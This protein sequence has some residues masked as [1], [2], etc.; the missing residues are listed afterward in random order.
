M[1]AFGRLRV[2]VCR[3]LVRVRPAPAASNSV[4]E[5]DGSLTPDAFAVSF[6]R[7]LMYSDLGFRGLDAAL[8]QV[9]AVVIERGLAGARTVFEAPFAN[10]VH[11]RVMKRRARHAVAIAI[12]AQAS[13]THGIVATDVQVLASS[14][15]IA[16][17]P[18]AGASQFADKPWISDVT[19]VHL[20]LLES[21]ARLTDCPQVES[22]GDT[23][24][25]HSSLGVDTFRAVPRV[26]LDTCTRSLDYSNWAIVPCSKPSKRGDAG[27]AVHADGL[28]A[29]AVFLVPEQI[30]AGVEARGAGLRQPTACAREVLALASAEALSIQPTKSAALATT[31]AVA[32]TPLFHTKR[33]AGSDV[34]ADATVV[35]VPAGFSIVAGRLTTGLPSVRSAATLH[36]APIA[37]R[38]MTSSSDF[39]SPL[40]FPSKIVPPH[41][42]RLDFGVR[43][44]PRSEMAIPAAN[45]R[46][47]PARG[48][49]V[50]PAL[51]AAAML[52]RM[53]EL[54]LALM[55]QDYCGQEPRYL[56][57]LEPSEAH[58]IELMNALGAQPNARTLPEDALVRLWSTYPGAAALALVSNFIHRYHEQTFWLSLEAATGLAPASLQ[59]KWGR[60]FRQFA[61]LHRLPIDR[62]RH[63]LK[64]VA[65]IQ[66]QAG[67]PTSHLRDVFELAE[68]ALD[69]AMLAGLDA[70][71]LVAAWVPRLDELARHGLR[72]PTRELFEHRPEV[73]RRYV[74]AFRALS[75]GAAVAGL[76][77]RFA[78]AFEAW[79]REGEAEQARRP[80]GPMRATLQLRK[81]QP[82]IVVGEQA[83]PNSAAVEITIQ[84]WK[85]P[86][87]V[88]RPRPFTRGGRQF[89]GECVIPV[90]PAESYLVH[91][92]QGTKLVVDAVPGMGTRDFL[93]FR[94]GRH[95]NPGDILPGAAFTAILPPHASID[96]PEQMRV[97]VD[98]IR[99]LWGR[100]RIEEWA[101][102]AS[103]ASVAVIGTTPNYRV[104][105]LRS[106][107]SSH[108]RLLGGTLVRESPEPAVY[109]T[110]PRVEVRGSPGSVV[111]LEE[112]KDG[113]WRG[114]PPT[115]VPIGGIVHV[116][117]PSRSGMFRAR[118]ESANPCYFILAPGLGWTWMPSELGFIVRAAHGVVARPANAVDLPAPSNET[119]L[120]VPI[121]NGCC[122][123]VLNACAA[124]L[125][126]TLRAPRWSIS[127]GDGT[128]D[129]QTSVVKIASRALAVGNL[130][131]HFEPGDVRFEQHER[132]VVLG[133]HSGAQLGELQP[134]PD[135][136]GRWKILLSD[137][138]DTFRFHQRDGFVVQWGKVDIFRAPSYWK[139]RYCGAEPDEAAAMLEHLR[140]EH[141]DAL[142]REWMPEAVTID[143]YDL[144]ERIYK[145]PSC[146]HYI[147]ARVWGDIHGLE[148]HLREC[149]EA[150]HGDK[151]GFTVIRDIDEIRRHVLR[152]LP[153]KY[154]C[155]NQTCN[156]ALMNASEKERLDHVLSHFPDDWPHDGESK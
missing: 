84:P 37:A 86:A 93:L 127:H 9:H 4:E 95:V 18:V 31:E 79:R 29:K 49:R 51:P 120:R 55:D 78:P 150:D 124:E 71:G 118:C 131:L 3:G 7:I 101:L 61:A 123:I 132:L 117:A 67:V 63:S 119:R 141:R 112:R 72:S 43:K 53:N 134:R 143:Q 136:R 10:V 28:C 108:L 8:A 22:N 90:P 70:A 80:S 64:Y 46:V 94:D 121:E 54:V 1:G 113:K 77:E 144:P 59:N 133:A 14:V 97:A 81:Q 109:S 41:R 30:V 50:G 122:K 140:Q 39:L 115:V 102:D 36:P 47:V 142:V 2:W 24:P 56:G 135:G 20:K 85:L 100:H 42:V 76:P 148:Q 82:S 11:Y 138:S 99:A 156:V 126:L 128:R 139:C 98:S 91:V 88:T 145:V 27:S 155:A 89:L 103:S 105:I 15:P 66:S 38:T 19:T 62:S 23:L 116:D 152:D 21:R 106:S 130:V 25:L 151:L 5:A 147:K 33:L 13:D 110:P 96:A 75:R 129:W 65:A 154:N 34:Q 73:A 35:L 146:S 68:A 153:R 137:Q 74:D 104:E 60:K 111:L 58:H 92:C 83:V 6:P 32:L 44:L 26:R 57:D 87:I 149:R 48:S 52:A 125:T 69:D 12:A 16:A 114:L 40:A 45:C 107:T 17:T